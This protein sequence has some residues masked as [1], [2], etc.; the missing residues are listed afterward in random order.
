MGNM[1]T[2]LVSTLAGG[3]K[4]AKTANAPITFID[5]DEEFLARNYIDRIIK[6][7][8]EKADAQHYEGKAEGRDDALR[9]R[10]AVPER[11]SAG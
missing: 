2:K 7:A 9:A 6:L 5:I 4:G 10:E 8:G 11:S 3:R 1:V